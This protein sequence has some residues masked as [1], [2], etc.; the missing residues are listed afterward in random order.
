MF[1]PARVAANAWVGQGGDRPRDV[2]LP[3]QGD[4]TPR[5]WCWEVGRDYR[6]AMRDGRARQ[7]AMPAHLCAKEQQM[8][9]QGAPQAVEDEGPMAK[10]SL[11]VE[12]R[13]HLIGLLVVEREA[14]LTAALRDEEAHQVAGRPV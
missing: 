5:V 7:A 8:K 4:V 11:A 9:P 10:A 2:E 1:C 14:A 13:V 6:W 12:L 3:D